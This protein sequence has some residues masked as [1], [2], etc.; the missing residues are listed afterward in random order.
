MKTPT[1]LRLSKRALF[2]QIGYEPHAGQLAVHRSKAPRRILCTGVRWGKTKCAAMEA[3][4]AALEPKARSVGWV[5]S[6]TYDLADRVFREIVVTAVEHLRHRIVS[7][8]EHDKRL[9]LTNLGGGT[10]EIRAKSAEN[11]M[12]LLGEGLD[13]V[14]IDEAARLKPTIW[15]AHLSQ[16]LVDRQGWALLISTPKGKGWLHVL[17]QR[18]Q[19]GGAP[20]HESWNFPSWG[21]PRLDRD[22]I[23]RQ[24]LLLPER[25]FAQ[26]YEG[27]FVEGA[28]QVLRY[29]REA[30]TGEWKEP[31]QG[32][33]Y[34]A[35]V[36]LAK[37]A[38][39]TVLTIMNKAREVVF[40]DRFNRLDWG[41]QLQ[42]IRAATERYNDAFTLV[43][44]T[45]GGEPVFEA[46][47]AAGIRA[48]GYPFTAA[49]KNALINNLALLFERREI[50]IPRYELFPTLVDELEAFEYSVTDSGN[51]RT[52]A[53]SGQHD[54]HVA[55]L[56]LAAWAVQSAPDYTLLGIDPRTGVIAPL[57]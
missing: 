22:L 28:G 31:V 6:G 16:R 15:E 10:S 46:M 7:L 57:M 48:E 21:N 45:G 12:S 17:W 30:A 42:R 19:A 53:P 54:D 23:E 34:F 18:G 36:D 2:Q 26:E 11:P 25:V 3:L 55:S 43:D 40:V 38:D 56:G 20:D 33:E 52:S 51:V 35:G 8:R 13:W 24:R 5:V 1:D 49:S 37:V 50:R 27:A 9:V 47:C 41:V 39:F 4:A 32:E 14:V 44:S 29:V